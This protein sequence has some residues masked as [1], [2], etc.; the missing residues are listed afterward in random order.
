MSAQGKHEFDPPAP[1]A[2]TRL[3]TWWRNAMEMASLPHDELDR[4]ARD[5][6]MTGKELEDIAAKGPH[7]ADLLYKR[8]AVLGLSKV[9]ADHL[10]FGLMRELQR[11]CACCGDKD[12]CKKDLAARPEDPF[13]TDYC[14]NAITLD[15]IA[16]AK[17]HALI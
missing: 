8:M 10:A 17:G 16:K 7:A 9:D 4:V 2:V 12:A 3:L 11:D 5:I 15:A 6:G 13:W 14:P 1:G